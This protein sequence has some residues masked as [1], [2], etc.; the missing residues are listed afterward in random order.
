MNVTCII[1]KAVASLFWLTIREGRDQRA[2]E[3]T[4]Q[5]R[6]MVTMEG[7]GE[8]EVRASVR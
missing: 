3:R 1:P 7:R 4:E 2:E 8:R 6:P 5:V